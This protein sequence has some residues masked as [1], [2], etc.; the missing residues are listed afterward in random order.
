MSRRK[1]RTP[2]YMARHE[3]N[4]ISHA[5][6]QLAH[7]RQMS[8]NLT[9]A[10]AFFILRKRIEFLNDKVTRRMD[11]GEPY[12]LYLE[13]REAMIWLMDKV[14]ELAGEKIVELYE[15]E[16]ETHDHDMDGLDQTTLE[17]D[18]VEIDTARGE[19]S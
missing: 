16:I 17:M 15:T 1:K 7:P 14:N 10:R 6:R 3:R 5:E 12:S 9:A 11:A 18:E 4:I 13:E 2:S 8:Y 19:L